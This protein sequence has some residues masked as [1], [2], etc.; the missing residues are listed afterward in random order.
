MTSQEREGL[1]EII[2]SYLEA[3]ESAP[4]PD[5]QPEQKRGCS[6]RPLHLLEPDWMPSFQTEQ[7]P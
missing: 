7:R 2:A 1:Q 3:E 4:L 5:F 6:S